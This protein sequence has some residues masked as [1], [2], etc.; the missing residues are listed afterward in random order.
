[1]ISL[2][3]FGGGDNAKLSLDVTSLLVVSTF[4]LLLLPFF[5]F[6]F[7]FVFVNREIS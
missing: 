7:S 5:F 3:L 1:M 4:L 6:F 2:L